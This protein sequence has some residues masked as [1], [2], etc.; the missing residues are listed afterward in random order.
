[1]TNCEAWRSQFH[2]CLQLEFS[3]P[4]FFQ[5]HHLVVLAYMLQTGAYSDRAFSEARALLKKW[6]HKDLTIPQ[7][8]REY[9]KKGFAVKT[10]AVNNNVDKYSWRLTILDVD[11][12][13]VTGYV[14][15]VARWA[16]DVLSCIED[17]EQELGRR[18]TG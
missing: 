2:Y 1:M 11:T 15:S 13:S 3:D 16:A 17:K 10:E 7:V 6:L 8:R 14:A 9:K 5:V 12:S 18:P 4:A